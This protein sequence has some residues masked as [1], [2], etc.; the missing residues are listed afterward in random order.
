MQCYCKL[1]RQFSQ[2]P[3]AKSLISSI[4]KSVLKS[5]PKSSFVLVYGNK[6]L[7]GTIFHQELHDLQLKYTGR[8]FVHYVYSQA[9]ADGALFGRIDKSVVNFAFAAFRCRRVRRLR[10]TLRCRLLHPKLEFARRV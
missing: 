10:R 4:L 8:L 5:E 3:F 6:S 9:K 2:I 7:E 1:S